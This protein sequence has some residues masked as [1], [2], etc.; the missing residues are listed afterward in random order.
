MKKNLVVHFEMPANDSKR[1]VEFY[2]GAFGWDANTLGPDM[3]E[4]VVVMTT[5]TDDKTNRPT[6][7]GAIN[8]GFYKKTP[9]MPL[10]HP[11]SSSPLTTSTST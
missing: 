8:G 11:Q 9:D 5:E 7:P 2:K 6:T 3:G 10:Q 4:Y 1:M